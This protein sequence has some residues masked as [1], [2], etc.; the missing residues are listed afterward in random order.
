MYL[1]Y[2]KSCSLFIIF[3]IIAAWSWWHILFGIPF[4]HLLWLFLCLNILNSAIRVYLLNRAILEFSDFSTIWIQYIPLASRE[5][6][7]SDSCFLYF[8]DGAIW[9]YG[10]FFSIRENTFDC[11]VR[12]AYLFCSICEMFLNLIIAK[13]ENLEP[14]R[15]GGLSGLSIWEI[16]DYLLIWESLFHIIVWEINYGIT[17]WPHLPPDPI[18]EHHLLLSVIIEPLHL[19]IVSLDLVHQLRG[20]EVL[21]VVTRGEFEVKF[22]FIGVIVVFER[23]SA[24]EVSTFND[25]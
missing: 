5:F 22:I 2:Q 8:L 10:L 12:E 1:H 6:D 19:A 13:F 24:G 3:H 25:S 14:I 18:A 4:N 11:A 17:I 15:E 20:N 23:I 21:A 7:D 16:V 9:E